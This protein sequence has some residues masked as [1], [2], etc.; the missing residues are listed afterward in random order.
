M[1]RVMMCK[2]SNLELPPLVCTSTVNINV[3]NPYGA[4]EFHYIILL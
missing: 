2:S 3:T 1:F 4:R